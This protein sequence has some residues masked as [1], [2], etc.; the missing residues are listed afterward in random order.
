MNPILVQ[1]A[2][3]VVRDRH[4][5]INLISSRV[6]RL[7]V[8]NGAEGR[9][10]LAESGSRSMADT[11]LL[12]LIEGRMSFELPPFTRLER[13]TQAGNRPKGWART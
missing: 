8:G 2:L 10:L 11:A 4:V 5:L 9:S 3:E 7:N 1:R 12:E 6:R 13:P